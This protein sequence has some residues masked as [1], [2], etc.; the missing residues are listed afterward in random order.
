MP[1]VQITEPILVGSLQ[2]TV[3]K[4][5]ALNTQVA[6]EKEYE[7][8]VKLTQRVRRV[9]ND[10]AQSNRLHLKEQVSDAFL[11]E[12]ADYVLTIFNETLPLRT[13]F[14]FCNF[15]QQEILVNGMLAEVFKSLMLTDARNGYMMQAGEVQ[16][17]DDRTQIY[18]QMAQMFEQTF[19]QLTMKLKAYLNVQQAYGVWW[20]W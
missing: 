2:V 6:Y 4:N 10:Y 16:I 1:M 17:Q 20:S 7:C 14:T 11:L 13:N 9:M 12:T 8:K 15:P 5:V 19:R 18:A 3:R